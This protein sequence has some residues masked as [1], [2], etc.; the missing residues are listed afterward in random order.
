MHLP[1]LA[2]EEGGIS[3]LMGESGF[4]VEWQRVVVEHNANGVRICTED[5]SYGLLRATAERAL[6]IAVFNDRN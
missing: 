1:E 6:V 5:L 2:L 3:G 4:I